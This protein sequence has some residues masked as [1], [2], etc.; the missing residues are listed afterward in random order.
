MRKTLGVWKTTI[1]G[2]V[3]FL[4]PFAVVVFLIGQLSAIIAP[5]AAEIHRRLPEG[6]AISFG[7]AS[8]ATVL[9]IVLLLVL[10]YLAGMV[11]RS[12][13]AARFAEKIEKNVRLLFPRYAILKN[14]IAS[15]LG[16]HAGEATLRPVAVRVPDGVRLGFETERDPSGLV[17]VYLPGAPDPW[18]GYLLHV[19]AE[20]VKPLDVS[21][22]DAAAVCESL[23]AGASQLLRPTKRPELE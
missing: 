12:A 2:G 19:E 11:A 15:N 14:Q 20:R 10:C 7:V 8:L 21:F 5:I 6:T 1:L 18:S 9:A 4:L 13:F 22:G 16:G 23:G 3:F 17:T